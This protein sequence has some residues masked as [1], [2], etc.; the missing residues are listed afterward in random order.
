M[1]QK[2]DDIKVGNMFN[3]R[4]RKSDLSKSVFGGFELAGKVAVL[5]P[6]KA[7][8]VTSTRIESQD[9]EYYRR[10]FSFERV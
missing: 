1:T 8:V 2:K 4:V 10:Y 5:S 3:A 7:T 9:S 6:E